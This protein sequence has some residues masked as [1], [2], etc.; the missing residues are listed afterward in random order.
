MKMALWKRGGF[1]VYE[2]Y[3]NACKGKSQNGWTL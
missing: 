3:Q 1:N 2:I